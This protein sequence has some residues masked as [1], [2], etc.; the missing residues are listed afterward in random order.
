MHSRLSSIVSSV[1]GKDSFDSLS[2][3]FHQFR[4]PTLAH[5]FALSLHPPSWFPPANTSLIVVDGLHTLVDIAYP[6]Y[7]SASQYTKSETAKWVSGRRYSALG[8]LV[9]ALKKLA[10]LHN[11]AILVTTGCATRMRPGTGFGAVLVPGVSGM[12]WDN[13]ITNRLVLFRDFPVR[14]A[15]NDASQTTK[16]A[17]FV[18]VTKLHGTTI[19]E[20]GD[21]GHIIEFEIHDSGIKGIG[22]AEVGKDD[23][24]AAAVALS[25]LPRS[26]VSPIKSRKRKLGVIDDSEDEIS[27]EYGWLAED[28]VAAEGMIDDRAL[29]ED[30]GKEATE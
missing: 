22:D 13:G 15:E 25:S 27:S 4:T 29:A 20:E 28:E 26:G 12:E 10:A 2:S 17:R 23:L 9:S 18:G 24:A 14:R 6:R 8:T 16:S 3:K 19:A 5:L 1:V 21:V 30:A 7:S 11:I